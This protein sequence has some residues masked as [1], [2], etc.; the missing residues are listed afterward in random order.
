MPEFTAFR[1]GVFTCF[2]IEDAKK[3]ARRVFLRQTGVM[4]GIGKKFD[5]LRLNRLENGRLVLALAISLAAH[6]LAWGGYEIGREFNFWQRL[7][8]G[9]HVAKM[10]PQQQQ[11]A[12]EPL[13]FV[14]VNQPSTEAPQK[15]KYYSD[16]NSRA[17]N[18]D[19]SRDADIPQINGRQTDVPKTE[20]AP[21]PQ[22][23]KTQPSPPQTQ[24]SENQRQQPSP[25]IQP[26]DL[27]LAKIDNLQPQQ[28]NNSP[29]PR[30]R[31]IKEALAQQNLL[32]GVK[33]KQDGGVRRHASISSLDVKLTG[34]GDY[35]AQ[36]VA[37]ISQ[38][39]YDLLDS[40]QFALD[41]T[42]KVVLQF[43]LNY[44]GTIT[45]MK[46][47]QNDV[48]ELLGYVCQKAVTDPAPFAKWP[49]EMRFKLGDS[50]DIQFTFYYY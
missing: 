50:R 31:T 34:F 11:I 27:T 22:F 5:S 45:D 40:Q 4:A 30:P 19:A 21:R 23:S 28:Q 17:A 24:P 9:Q 37:A 42:G 33:M 26:G 15:A 2:A 48:G 20:D 49:G 12:E 6:L 44:D 16:K 43:H 29:P 13:T 3:V 32:P 47:V 18:P 46:V 25:T 10:I 14:T 1:R 41:R 7:N 38:R 36:L 35:D 8:P 39:W